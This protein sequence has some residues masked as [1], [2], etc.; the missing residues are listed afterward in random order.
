MNTLLKTFFKRK[1]KKIRVMWFN[2]PMN[3]R[4]RKDKDELIINT[5]NLLER[6]IKIK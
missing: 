2:V 4:T 3:C 1:S 6:L 5:I